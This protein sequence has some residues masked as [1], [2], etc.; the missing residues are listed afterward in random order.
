MQ[1]HQDKGSLSAPVL[2][3]AHPPM[4]HLY[5]SFLRSEDVAPGLRNI[6]VLAEIS[7]ERV[8]LRNAYKAPGQKAPIRLVGGQEYQLTGELEA[9]AVSELICY[10]KKNAYQEQ[11][12]P[13]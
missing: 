3:A 8:P 5:C 7:R 4:L 13:F 12:L 9:H 10:S 6:V 11:Q 2:H 1:D